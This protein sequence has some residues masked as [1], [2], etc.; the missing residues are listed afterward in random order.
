MALLERPHLLPPSKM[1]TNHAVGCAE[2]KDNLQLDNLE[3]DRWYNHPHRHSS[4]EGLLAVIRNE[5]GAR[6]GMLP[7]TN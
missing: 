6:H 3:R 1:L 5:D 4:L 2:W 7:P